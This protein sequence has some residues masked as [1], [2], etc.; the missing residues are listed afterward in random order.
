M[1]SRIASGDAQFL[2]LLQQFAQN[3]PF[4]STP[5]STIISI[6]IATALAATAGPRAMRSRSTLLSLQ[7]PY[8][9]EKTSILQR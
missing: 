5:R 2:P 1:G 7:G 8:W 9:E 4:L 3:K 6:T